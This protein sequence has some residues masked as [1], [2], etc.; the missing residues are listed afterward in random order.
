MSQLIRHLV[1]LFL[2]AAAIQA[3]RLVDEDLNQCGRRAVINYELKLVTD[4]DTQI[5]TELSEESDV[6]VAKALKKHLSTVFADY[7]H[8]L[9]LS[10]YDVKGDSVRLHHESHIMDAN[11]SSYTI[12]IPVRKYM[13]L[14]LANISLMPSLTFEGYDHCRSSRLIQ[15]VRDSIDVQDAGVYTAR[16]PM[17]VKADES[18][19][20]QVHLYMANSAVALIVYPD[21]DCEIGDMK[22]CMTGFATSFDVSDS[23]YHYDRS[24]IVRSVE[25]PVEGSGPKCFASVNLPSPSEPLVKSGSEKI[26]W[27]VRAYVTPKGGATTETTLG[28]YEPLLAGHLK[29]IKVR[30]KKDGTIEPI[31]DSM[32]VSVVMEWN[33]GLNPTI[34]F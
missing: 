8:D 4:L 2:G 13:H 31:N 10:F 15:P 3:C 33:P 24:P 11:Q 22:V 30:A 23:L 32:A 9:D 18:Q 21:E 26:L 1:L 6:E 5:D 20:F 29:I 12:Y 19:S 17:D 27:E 34:E 16:L 14:A 25:V 7:A 28:L